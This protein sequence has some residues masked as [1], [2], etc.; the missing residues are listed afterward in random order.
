MLE[1]VGY[2]KDMRVF[3]QLGDVAISTSQICC[4]DLRAYIGSNLIAKFNCITNT[5]FNIINT[6]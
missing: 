2:S 4:K 5:S 1:N 6:N 3:H